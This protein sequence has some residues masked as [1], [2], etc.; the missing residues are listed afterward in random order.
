MM[1]F[2]LAENLA[3]VVNIDLMKLKIKQINKGT[4]DQLLKIICQLMT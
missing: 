1:Y 4:E 3:H 2:K